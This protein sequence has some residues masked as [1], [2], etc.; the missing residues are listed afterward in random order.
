MGTMRLELWRMPRVAFGGGKRTL[1]EVSLADRVFRGVLGPSA[2]AA[3]GSAR[4]VLALFWRPAARG[5]LPT[6]RLGRGIPRPGWTAFP[7]PRA[8]RQ[9][10]AWTGAC[11]A[12]QRTRRA[13]S[14]HVVIAA[15][16][17][18]DLPARK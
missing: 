16:L 13:E 2:P 9:R 7:S 1:R 6:R 8:P 4:S 15:C 17:S 14:V 3:R 5:C 12:S 10:D 18:V 11:M